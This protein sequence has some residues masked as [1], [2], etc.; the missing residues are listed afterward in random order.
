MGSSSFIVLCQP[1]LTINKDRGRNTAPRGTRVTGMMRKAASTLAI[2]RA[3]AGRRWSGIYTCVSS[4]A[5]RHSFLTN[6]LRYVVLQSL[7]EPRAVGKALT[8]SVRQDGE[9]D[10]GHA[11][12]FGADVDRGRSSVHMLCCNLG[13]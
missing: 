11:D 12:F 10:G 9:E 13:C 6:A 7:G 5:I 8:G 3:R 2:R 4:L 1:Q